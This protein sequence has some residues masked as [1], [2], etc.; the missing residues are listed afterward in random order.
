LIQSGNE[1]EISQG[2]EVEGPSTLCARV[3][4]E[5]ARS[6]AFEVGGSAV[7]VARGEFRL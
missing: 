5:G 6:T 3:F 1:I 7:V 2:A 4:G